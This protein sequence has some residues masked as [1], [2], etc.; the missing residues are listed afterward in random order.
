MA[1]MRKA[2]VSLLL[3]S[4]T[5]IPAQLPSVEALTQRVLSGE[6][7]WKNSD[8][9]YYL[10]AD[11]QPAELRRR[12]YVATVIDFLQQ[13]RAQCDTYYQSA[14]PARRMNYEDLFYLAKQ[15]S[16]SESGEVDN[17]A[18]GP[19]VETLRS[20]FEDTG[21]TNEDAFDNGWTLFRLSREA[22]KYVLCVVWQLLVRDPGNLNH[23]DCVIDLIKSTEARE[24]HSFTLNHDT[25]LERALSAASIQFN[26]GFGESIEGVR[27]WEPTYFERPSLR[28]DLLKVHGSI[29]WFSFPPNEMAPG[30]ESIGIPE[31]WD[32]WH[33][34]SPTGQLQWPREGTPEIL[35]GTFNKML[36]YT[37]RVYADIY[38]H[39]RRFLSGSTRLVISGYGFGDKAINT[40]IIEW[41][42]LSPDRQILLIDPTPGEIPDRARYAISKNLGAWIAQ[43]RL[44]IIRSGIE[45][46]TGRQLREFSY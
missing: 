1:S 28:V 18:V 43:R 24:V 14:S 22:E 42:H 12:H 29:N 36:A 2:P 40:Q 41:L 44:V 34:S 32:F 38:F 27:Y 11:E 37:S 26:D 30:I 20:K 21:N 4:G 39:F 35:L 15:I 25:V 45:D 31:S 6:G 33:T 3:G 19:L 13:L 7:V 16:D 8:D 9:N 23:L 10:H 5:S 46:V 17:P